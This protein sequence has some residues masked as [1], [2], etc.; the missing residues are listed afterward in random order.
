MALFRRRRRPLEEDIEPEEAAPA[1]DEAAAED[2]RGPRDSEGLPAPEGYVDLGSV[3]V[4]SITGLQLRGKVGPDKVTLP[5]VMLVLGASGVTVSVA[6]APKSGGA[7]E[8]LSEQI[9]ASIRSQGGSTT[10]VD[11]PY[12]QEIQAKVGTTLPDG[13]KGFTPLRIIGVEG[14]RWVA[15]LDIA[16]AAAAGDAAQMEAC[17][18]LIDQLIVHRGDAPQIRLGLLPLTLPSE[19]SGLDA[20]R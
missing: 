5:R 1:L 4:P 9:E 12:G 18:Q 2:Q 13:T 7:W 8:E 17:E 20:S 15:R 10:R 3:Y 16:G 19:A 14:P 6:A 11:G